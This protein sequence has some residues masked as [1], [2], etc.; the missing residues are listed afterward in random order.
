[1]CFIIMRGSIKSAA[2]KCLAPIFAIAIRI[3]G[4]A[5]RVA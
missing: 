3:M 1:M 2:M 5:F 4:P